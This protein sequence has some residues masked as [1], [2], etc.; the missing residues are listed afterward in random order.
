METR[1]DLKW[2]RPRLR[3]K[4]SMIGA[5]KTLMK[6]KTLLE[7]VIES[8]SPA[9]LTGCEEMSY[10]HFRAGFDPLRPDL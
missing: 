10:K 6:P 4:S 2:Y 9:Y 5:S 3:K 1:L 7:N 8:T